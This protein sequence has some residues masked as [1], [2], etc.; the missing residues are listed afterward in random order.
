[1]YEE[2]K[3]C[4]A[5]FHEEES[6]ESRVVVNE[7]YVVG[8]VPIARWEGTVDITVDVFEEASCAV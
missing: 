4:I 7:Q 3:G 1:L 5:A 8:E 2:G 6:D